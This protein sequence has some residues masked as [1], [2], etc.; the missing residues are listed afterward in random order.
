MKN[1][2]LKKL[3]KDDFSD[4]M[5]IIRYINCVHEHDENYAKYEKTV[6]ELLSLS[7]KNLNEAVTNVLKK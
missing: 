3:K 5:S 1:D 6:N 4:A 2:E 7:K